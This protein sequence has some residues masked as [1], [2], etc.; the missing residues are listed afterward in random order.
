M[1]CKKP[2]LKA[3]ILAI[4]WVHLLP[5]FRQCVF[6]FLLRRDKY[7]SLYKMLDCLSCAGKRS[8]KPR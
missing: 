5:K 1:S 4:G 2:L 7:Y 6:L 8:F 3:Y